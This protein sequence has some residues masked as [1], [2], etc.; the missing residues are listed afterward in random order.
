MRRK[1][2][3]ARR[4]KGAIKMNKNITIKETRE[5]EIPDGFVCSG[6]RTCTAL[7]TIE[8]ASKTRVCSYF[9]RYVRWSDNAG[10]YQKCEE[11]VNAT[12]QYLAG[13]EQEP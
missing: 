8:N 2:R 7:T 9:N 11:C 5:I 12:M 4:R 13:K 10:W 3:M 1:L 6:R